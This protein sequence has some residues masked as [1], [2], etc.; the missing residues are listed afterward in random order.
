MPLALPLQYLSVQSNA[1]TNSSYAGTRTLSVPTLA[2]LSCT[3]WP[4]DMRNFVPQSTLGGVW[5][6][7]QCFRSPNLE[8][9]SASPIRALLDGYTRFP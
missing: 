5:E 6:P 8:A 4:D 1:V 7:K 9:S 3:L 2:T